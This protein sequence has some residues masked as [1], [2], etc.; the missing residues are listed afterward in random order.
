LAFDPVTGA[1]SIS[2]TSLR[3]EDTWRLDV[4]GNWNGNGQA[5]PGRATNILIGEPGGPTIGSNIRDLTD[6]QNRLVTRLTDTGGSPQTVHLA[7][8]A[9]GNLTCDGTYY[10]QY[11]AWNRLIQVN[12]A[13]QQSVSPQV[14]A[15]DG[16]TLVSY[17]WIPDPTKML[18]HHT[19]DG[20]GRLVRTQSPS[21]TSTTPTTVSAPSESSGAG[22]P[23][24][25][26]AR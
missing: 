24:S 8:D 16:H 25:R 17:I 21:P 13:I 23:L 5:L 14:L 12:R 1:P 9:A 7:F 20:V 18:K 26:Q 19:Y 15:S 11:D 6:A 10:Y 2:P 22:H 3:R 4:V